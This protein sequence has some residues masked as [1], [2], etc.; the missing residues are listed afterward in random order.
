MGRHKMPLILPSPGTHHLLASPV[1]VVLLCL[2]RTTG[3][4]L[5][6]LPAKLQPMAIR[7]LPL[8]QVTPSGWLLD[9]LVLQANSL[10]G[11]VLF[12]FLFL[13]LFSA[14]KEEPFE[15]CLGQALPA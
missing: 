12:L 11:C 14:A 15:M 4:Q 2:S 8:G 13:F 9:Q 10:S 6:E 3:E 5:P 7:L 1:A